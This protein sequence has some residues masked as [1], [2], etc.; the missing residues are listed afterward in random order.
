[1]Q[2]WS[3]YNYHVRVAEADHEL[4]LAKLAAASR[5]DPLLQAIVGLASAGSSYVL[6]LLVGGM[7]VYGQTS[8]DRPLAESLD[9]E[10]ER[11]VARSRKFSNEPEL[12][13]E[14][15]ARVA[16][17]WTQGFEEDESERQEMIERLSDRTF[18]ELTQEEKREVI[19]DRPQ[20]MT[21]VAVRVFPPGAAQHLEVDV[22]R[23]PLASIDAWWLIPTDEDGKASF[24]HP[25]R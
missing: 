21:L 7:T 19:Q 15:S 11:F 12:W 22:L 18:E 24:T 3:P 14:V 16:G 17:M 8:T 13:D 20:N 9:A 25:V 1:V 6:G 5:R 4:D 10:H 23:V 2:L